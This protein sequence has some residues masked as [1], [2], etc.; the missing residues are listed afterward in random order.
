MSRDSKAKR[1]QYSL[2]NA[3]NVEVAVVMGKW[4]NMDEICR[5]VALTP[6]NPAAHH[7]KGLTEEC[8]GDFSSAAKHVRKAIALLEHQSDKA[9]LPWTGTVLL[10]LHGRG[11][12]YYIGSVCQRMRNEVELLWFQM[13]HEPSCSDCRLEVQKHALC[14][15]RQSRPSESSRSAQHCK[16]TIFKLFLTVYTIS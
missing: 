14:T 13:P 11:R 7:A 10:T 4:L 8:R 12:P 15:D 3:L 16:G 1:M 2:K 6:L 9:G 5:A